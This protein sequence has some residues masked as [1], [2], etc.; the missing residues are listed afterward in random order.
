MIF[1][2]RQQR[3]LRELTSLESD[4]TL[5]DLPLS[6]FGFVFAGSLEFNRQYDNPLF[7]IRVAR[8]QATRSSRFE[9]HHL[10]NGDVL[11]IAFTTEG[12]ATDLSGSAART[13]NIIASPIVWGT[14]TSLISL[15]LSS[16]QSARRRELDLSV[17]DSIDVLDIVL[18]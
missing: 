2:Q 1:S 14:M 10:S 17:R 13:R 9:I 11:L 6:T 5:V 15:P 18:C 4:K 16:V 12:T 3:G 7:R 8:F